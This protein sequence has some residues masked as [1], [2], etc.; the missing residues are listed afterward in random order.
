[1]GDWL[2]TLPFF[3]FVTQQNLALLAPE[4]IVLST[5]IV[6]LFSALSKSERD[7]QDTWWLILLGLVCT[8][9]TL[10]VH[11]AWVYAPLSTDVGRTTWLNQPVF[12]GLFQADVFALV[13]RTLLVIG[14]LLVVLFSRRYLDQRSPVPGEFYVVLLSALLGGMLLSGAVDL[15]LVF[16]ALETLSISSYVLVGFLRGHWPSTE[17]AL[18][19]LVYGGASTAVFLFGLSLLY[20][21]SGG[22]TS[23]DAIASFFLQPGHTEALAGGQFLMPLMIVMILAGLAFKLSIAP[24]HMWTPDVY[25]G[26]PTPVTGFLSV[27]SKTAAFALTLRLLYTVLP[28]SQ[29]LSIV[30]ATLAVLSMTFGNL[31]AVRQRNLKRLLGFSTIAHVGYMLLGIVVFS[32]ESMAMVVYYLMTYLVM[33]LGAF[34]VVTHMATLTGGCEDIAAYGGLIQ[35]RPWLVATFVFFLLSLAGIPITAGF[36]GKLFLFGAVAHAGA[37]YLWLVIIALLNSVVG[38]YYY[39]NVIRVMMLE[40]ASEPVRELSITGTMAGGVSWV[41]GISL[42]GT[43]AMGI[44]ARP[45]VALAQVS[46]EQLAVTQATYVQVPAAALPGKSHSEN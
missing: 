4:L 20:G 42:V 40:P 39:L 7:R 18:K 32:Q 27:V 35:R 22:A 21:M 19:Y 15:I 16:V 34:A 44:L 30:L 45:F 1:M 38:L 6:C 24:F 10:I 37:G 43:L 3:R 28:H 17:A 5:L 33:N 2:I 11:L 46:I 41:L 8:L 14:S 23:F 26:A 36:F 13:I 9:L 12:Y 29:A 31:G 25:E